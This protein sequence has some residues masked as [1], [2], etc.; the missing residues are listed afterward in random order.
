[1]SVKGSNLES[2]S[3]NSPQN[4]S[5]EPHP[6]RTK[7]ISRGIWLMEIVLQGKYMAGSKP[8][9]KHTFHSPGKRN[10]GF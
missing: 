10:A 2:D 9:T 7:I 5:Q 6:K 3:L 1:M 8:L 4:I